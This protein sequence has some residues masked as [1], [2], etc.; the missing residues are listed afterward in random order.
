[1]EEAFSGLV[2]MVMYAAIAGAAVERKPVR[3]EGGWEESQLREGGERAAGEI[4]LKEIEILGRD[5]VGRE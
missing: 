3:I 4:E 1:M 2:N 5:V